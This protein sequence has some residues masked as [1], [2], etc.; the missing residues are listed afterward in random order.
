[1]VEQTRRL[2]RPFRKAGP[3]EEGRGKPGRLL[4][5]ADRVPHQRRADGET[6]G[7]PGRG[8]RESC[9]RDGLAVTKAPRPVL[10]RRTGPGTR[11]SC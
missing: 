2:V 11:S 1:M 6:A 8:S 7:N 9:C 10:A 4:Y 3:D 5:D